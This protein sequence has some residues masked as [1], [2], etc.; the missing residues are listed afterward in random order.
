MTTWCRFRHWPP[1]ALTL[2]LCPEFEVV[3]DDQSP[4]DLPFRPVVIALVLVAVRV[5]GCH[6]GSLH[7]IIYE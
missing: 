5:C 1:N 6:T 2:V 7:A 3:A 4:A